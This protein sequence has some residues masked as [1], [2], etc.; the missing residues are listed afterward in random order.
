MARVCREAGARVATNA[1]LRDMNVAG[2]RARDGRRIEVLASGLPLYQGQQLAVDTTLVSPVRRTGV[3]RPGAAERGGVAAE[4]AVQRKRRTYPEL[5]D[6]RR[7]RLQVF[8]VEVGGRWDRGA[9]SFIRALAEARA[10]SAPPLLRR[11]AALA[12]HRRWTGMLAVAAQV[13]FAASLLEE[14]LLGH[15]LCDGAAPEL[16]EVL[17]DGAA[18]EPPAVSRMG[19]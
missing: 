15:D 2:V 17:H 8:A 9:W 6:G 5:V 4:A 13:A 12:W 16:A 11:S 14:P 3:P 19:A 18:G 1:F 10:R 7:C